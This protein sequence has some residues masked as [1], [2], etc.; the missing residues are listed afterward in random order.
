LSGEI[1]AKS[2]NDLQ[3]LFLVKVFYKNPDHWKLSKMG[4]KNFRNQQKIYSDLFAP[5][6]NS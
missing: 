5:L 3:R 1:N 2:G 6:A 4:L